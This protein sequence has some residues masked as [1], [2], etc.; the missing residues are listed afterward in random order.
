MS[1]SSEPFELRVDEEIV[2]RPPYLSIAAE[3]FQL[4]D[5][6]REYLSEWMSW[7]PNTNSVEDVA[8]F[9]HQTTASRKEGKSLV[10]VIQ[11]R[12]QVVGVVGFNRISKALRMAELG[13]WLAS[14]HQRRGIML[15]SCRAMI[16]YA[17]QTLQLEKIEIR[18]AQEN[19]RSRRV[20]ENL[21]ST[22]EGVIS[23]SDRLGDRILSHAVYGLLRPS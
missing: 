5:T 14:D 22:L 10:C 7:T 11:Y 12:D 2:L 4:V 16:D 8:E 1:S 13:Y 6:N 15:R 3:L 17:F 20:C 21:G 18:A 23:H 9:I 19:H